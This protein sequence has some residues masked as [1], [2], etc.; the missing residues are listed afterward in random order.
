MLLIYYFDFM[1]VEVFCTPFIR[2]IYWNSNIVFI[3][4]TNS[5][6]AYIRFINYFMLTAW[7]Q[8]KRL[9]VSSIQRG[10]KQM[11]LWSIKHYSFRFNSDSLHCT[12]ILKHRSVFDTFLHFVHIKND[13]TITYCGWIFARWFIFGKKWNFKKKKVMGY[14]WPGGTWFS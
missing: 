14:R 5:V 7:N 1:Y 2:S 13:P 11:K 12:M 8:F 10:Q 3:F 6:I 9:K 4:E